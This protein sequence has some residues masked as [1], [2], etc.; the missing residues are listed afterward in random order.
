[1]AIN[2][3]NKEVETTTKIDVVS[4]AVTYVGEAKLGASESSAVWQI[5]KIVKSGT[6]VSILSAN[7]NLR[8]NNIWSDRATLTYG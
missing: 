1:M 5:L 2:I 8:F 6:V 3:S 7:S 4:S